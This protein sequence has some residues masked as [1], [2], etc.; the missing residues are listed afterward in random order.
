MT[1]L[2]INNTPL[3]TVIIPVYNRKGLLK[4][5]LQS[6]SLQKG[7]EKGLIELIL[8]DNG[9]TDGA[10]EMMECWIQENSSSYFNIKLIYESRRG[11]C[12][13]RNRGLSVASGEWMMFFDSDDIMLP[14]H[15]SSVLRSIDKAKNADVIYWDVAYSDFRRR[16]CG[17]H[18]AMIGNDVWFNVIIRGMLSTQRYCCRKT[19]I[20]SI[21]GWNENIYIW[22]DWELSV[23]IVASGARL[24]KKCGN[25]TVE[26]V[27]HDDSITGKYFCN[28][29][30]QREAAL[31]CARAFAQQ[32]GLRRVVQ[33]IDMKGAVLAGDYGREGASLLSSKL[34]YTLCSYGNVAK[35]KLRVI[36]RMEKIFGRGATFVTWMI[37]RL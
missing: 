29:A 8:V 2:S 3:L 21:G 6:I 1:E 25:T 30:G 31:E 20:E 19:F 34:L 23:R 12:V 5:T 35:W 33:L 16:F 27:V 10:M 9:S 14:D 32:L 37:D 22:N 28:K 11:V 26:I 4:E 7:V 17:T 15:L 18:K 36:A 24:M 13:A